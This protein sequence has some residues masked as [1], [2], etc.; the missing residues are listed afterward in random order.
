ME[1][2]RVGS[3]TVPAQIVRR[4]ETVK[5]HTLLFECR[6]IKPV[7]FEFPE[8]GES[9]QRTMALWG[10]FIQADKTNGRLS[11]VEECAISSSPI[12]IQN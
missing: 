12:F 3:E 1:A 10:N 8:D 9:Q 6:S 7:S 2:Q 11:L 5:S 4:G